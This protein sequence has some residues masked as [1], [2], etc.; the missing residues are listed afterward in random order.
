MSATVLPK[1]FTTMTETSAHFSVS[2]TRIYDF[3]KTDPAIIVRIG[4]RTL[5]DVERLKALIASMPRGPR[6]PSTPVNRKGLPRKT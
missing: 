5:V 2:K 3:A 4:G 1:L 6:K